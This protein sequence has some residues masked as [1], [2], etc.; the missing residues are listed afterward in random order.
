MAQRSSTRESE[1]QI[2]SPKRRMAESSNCSIR[3]FFID[4]A[5]H[6]Y[7]HRSSGPSLGTGQSCTR[8][9]SRFGVYPLGC[10]MRTAPLVRVKA[11]CTVKNAACSKW[12][13]RTYGVFDCE[14]GFHSHE[15]SCSEVTAIACKRRDRCARA[16]PCAHGRGRFFIYFFIFIVTLFQVTSNTPSPLHVPTDSDR[17][18]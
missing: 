17:G 7:R 3:C 12:K 8:W 14:F 9:C 15:W 18:R 10:D 6:K 13:T 1:S 11:K 4:P 2:H 16:R 5:N